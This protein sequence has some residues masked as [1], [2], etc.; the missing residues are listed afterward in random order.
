VGEHLRAK[1]RLRLLGLVTVVALALM[2]AFASLAQ[3]EDTPS[4]VASVSSSSSLYGEAV[5]VTL[6]A[7][8]PLGQPYG[9][10]L[11]FRV[12]LPKGVS[13][14]GG[15]SVAPTE[16]ADRPTTGET[17]L[18]FSNVADLSPNSHKEFGLDLTYALRAE[19]QPDRGTGRAVGDQLHRVQR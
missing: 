1:W 2:G 8:N 7:E 11:S 14:G 9:Y 13:Y 5:P 12:L 4:I 18:I 3:A 15:A 10:N 19:V 17:T 16:I 6:R